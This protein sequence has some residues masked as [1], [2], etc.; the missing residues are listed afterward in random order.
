MASSFLDR[1]ELDIPRLVKAPAEIFLGTFWKSM[2]RRDLIQR[3][4]DY[5]PGGV[6]TFGIQVLQ[7]PR[8]G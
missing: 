6:L 5:L 8:Q 3:V 1:G 4:K 2:G 7:I